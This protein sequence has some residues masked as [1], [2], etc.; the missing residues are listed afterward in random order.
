M[1]FPKFSLTPQDGRQDLA[2]CSRC[3]FCVSLKPRGA[4]FYLAALSATLATQAGNESWGFGSLRK[5]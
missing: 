5:L 1:V 3:T 2:A 4:G